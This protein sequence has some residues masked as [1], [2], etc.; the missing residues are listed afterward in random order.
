[1]HNRL[2]NAIAISII[3]QILLVKWLGSYP[4]FIESYY[5]KGLYLYWSGF[6]RNLL[7]WLPFSVGDL[8][9]GFLIVSLIVYLVKKG[10]YMF[11]DWKVLLR[12]FA[13]VLSVAYFTFHISW[14]FNY[15]REPIS[16]VFDLE[17]NEEY[18]DL[19]SITE[20]LIW[21][22]N[23]LQYSITRDSS[24][25]VRIP[26]NQKEIFQHTLEA[27]ELFSE[28]YPEM[29]YVKPSLKKSLF[30]TL[31]TYMGY[32]GYLNPFTHESQVNS[33]IPNFRFPVVC[34]HEVGHQIGYSAENE[35]NF[36]GYLVMASYQDIHLQYAAYAYALSHCLSTLKS[37]DEA[38]YEMLYS[39]LNEGVLKNFRELKAFWQSYKNP[40]E[41]IFKSVFN[42]FLKVNNQKAGIQSYSLVVP[43][44]VA[45][46]KSTPWVN[47][48]Y[49]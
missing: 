42:T 38:R 45:Y 3:P 8:L 24:E 16:N 40:M 33:R 9:Y 26:Y 14:G 19:V 47:K 49:R 23:N 41:P 35:V 29:R 25:I 17:E 18:E 2:K 46:H 32:G 31:L 12:D 34:A 27:Y 48:I 15:Y 20:A 30:S 39:Q 28:Q 5:S 6:F 7:G 10:K 11:N 1:M 43:L 4:A 44:I 21:K 36:M 13:L 37:K 22:T